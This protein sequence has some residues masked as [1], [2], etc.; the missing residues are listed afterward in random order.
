MG[1]RSLVAAESALQQSMQRMCNMQVSEKCWAGA[2]RFFK[3]AMS[4][5]RYQYV[6]W[7]WASEEE[8]EGEEEEEE[9]LLP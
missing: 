7:I 5:R 4:E 1:L 8:D 3:T 9:R 6:S 2:G